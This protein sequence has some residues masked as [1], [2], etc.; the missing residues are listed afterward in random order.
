MDT[1]IT[2]GDLDILIN[3]WA[4]EMKSSQDLFHNQLEEV[5]SIS[6]RTDNAEEKIKLIEFRIAVLKYQQQQLQHDIIKASTTQKDLQRILEELEK[7]VVADE[8]N[9]IVITDVLR[10]QIYELSEKI[11]CSIYLCKDEVE[12][13]KREFKN[14]DSEKKKNPVEQLANVMMRLVETLDNMEIKIE[15]MKH[16]TLWIDNEMQKYVRKQ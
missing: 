15:K 4:S 16:A 6:L 8:E 2:F 14:K 10:Q 9:T 1:K 11:D 3:Y 5:K 13:L 12:L 7:V